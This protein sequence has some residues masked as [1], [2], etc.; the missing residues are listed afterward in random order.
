M[1]EIHS[2]FFC[3]FSSLTKE[4]WCNRE[5]VRVVKRAATTMDNLRKE[6][7]N[8]LRIAVLNDFGGRR[9]CHNVLFVKENLPMK[10]S[11]WNHRLYYIWYDVAH[12]DYKKQIW[13]YIPVI[14]GGSAESKK[15]G[16]PQRKQRAFSQWIQSA[17]GW[18]NRYAK[19]T[20]FWPS[21]GWWIK[22][23]W[24]F[25]EPIVPEYC[26]LHSW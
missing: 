4:L 17:M 16:I 13:K 18:N 12:N 20:W 22:N 7:A 15:Q 24:Y 10:I 19:T 21:V 11:Q 23:V 25:C 9:L 6:Y 14:G 26:Y 1:Q 3:Y 5:R 8:W 2:L